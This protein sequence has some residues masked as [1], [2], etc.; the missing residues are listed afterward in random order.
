MPLMNDPAHA[1]LIAFLRAIGSRYTRPDAMLLVSG[2]WEARVPTLNAGTAP[3][4]LYDYYGFPPETYRI[5]YPAPGQPELARRIATLLGQGG[6]ASEFVVD[7]GYDHGVFVPLKLAY[8]EADVPIVQLSL[9]KGLNAAQHIE[10]GRCLAPLRAQNVA[11]IGSGMS[12]HNLQALFAGERADLRAAS[13]L[14]DQWLRDTVTDSA[15]TEVARADALVHWANAPYARFCHPREEHLLPLH[16]CY[17]AA[18]APGKVLFNEP[19]M[20]HKVSGFGW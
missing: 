5:A 18:S 2:H 9:I 15:V 7:R 6:F 10:L 11:I 14:F 19:L 3:P 13:D 8:P 16:V 20:G 1:G 4:L 12:F 17:G